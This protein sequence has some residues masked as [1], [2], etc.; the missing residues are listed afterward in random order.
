MKPTIAR[1][2]TAVA[3]HAGAGSCDVGASS[4]RANAVRAAVRR[5][6]GL[7]TNHSTI[8][9]HASSRWTEPH[10][11]SPLARVLSEG[12]NGS[13]CSSGA[14]HPS[15]AG[16]LDVLRKSAVDTRGHAAAKQNVEPT[17]PTQHGVI[18]AGAYDLRGLSAP[19]QPRIRA[20]FGHRQEARDPGG[21]DDVGMGIARFARAHGWQARGGAV[22][23]GVI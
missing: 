3:L 12:K 15:R 23:L 5:C 8:A 21:A 2:S 17:G 6:V 13:R 22:V 7:A 4:R 18:A 10:G 9:V 11:P 20:L 19:H 14:H 1:R 16:R